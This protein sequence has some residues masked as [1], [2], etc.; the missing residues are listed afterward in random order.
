MKNFFVPLLLAIALLLPTT[1]TEAADVPDF[2]SVAGNSVSR[3][4]WRQDSSYY[5]YVYGS[6]TL[7]DNFIERYINLLQQKYPFKL[8]NHDYNDWRSLSGQYLDIWTFRYTGSKR[9]S[10]PFL[11]GRGQFEIWRYKYFSEGR[12]SFSIKVADGLTYGGNS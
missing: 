11:D 8:I 2:R 10:S 1:I 12:T 6:N 9:V 4:D 5:A 3:G 7:N